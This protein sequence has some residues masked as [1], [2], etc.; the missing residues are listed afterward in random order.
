MRRVL[1][2]R[3]RYYAAKCNINAKCNTNAKC[4]KLDAKYNKIFN[5]KCNNLS[6]QI[7]ITFL[8]H[9][10]ITQNVIIS[11]ITMCMLFQNR[12]CGSVISSWSR[13]SCELLLLLLSILILI[14]VIL[15][16]YFL[17]LLII[18]ITINEI[19]VE[20][21]CYFRADLV[22]LDR[23]RVLS[24]H[25]TLFPNKGGGALRDETKMAARACCTVPQL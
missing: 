10:V 21:S 19:T 4:N 2:S 22:S 8:T 25:A 23:S 16:I 3:D 14:I 11:E 13:S 17:L 18:I 9:N 20:T 12:Y 5:A 24:R 15:N 6:T 1:N 7:V